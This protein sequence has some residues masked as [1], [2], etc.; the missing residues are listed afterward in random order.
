MEG[1]PVIKT[2]LF[3]KSSRT[4]DSCPE[5]VYPEYAFAG[6]SNVGKSSLINYL[7]NRH[8]L[9]R[10]SSSP[11]KTLLI[12]HYMLNDRF[13]F[14]DLPGYGYARTSQKERQ[15]IIKMIFDYIRNRKNLS[16]L[17][18]LIDPRMEPMENDKLVIRWLGETGIPFVIVFTKTDKLSTVM[19]N[20]NI[21]KYRRELMAD[22]EVL[23]TFFLTSS[24]E[25]RGRDEILELI[26]KTAQL[27]R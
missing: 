18:L 8:Y 5:P 14:V 24:T 3:I 13:Y 9:A 12:N 7:T 27:T 16:C 1:K 23:P 17:F 15:K 6:R 20:R 10:T 26:Y 19:L 2:A 22:W 4:I 21:E 11:G 25:R